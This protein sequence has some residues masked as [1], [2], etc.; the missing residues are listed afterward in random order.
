MSAEQQAERPVGTE[1]FLDDEDSGEAAR[2]VEQH[3][4]LSDMMTALSEMMSGQ[5]TMD[6]LGTIRAWQM[7]CAFMWTY[8]EPCPTADHLMGPLLAQEESVSALASAIE[9]HK[10]C[11]DEVKGAMKAYAHASK[12]LL[13]RMTA[14][15]WSV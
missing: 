3:L 4:D 11:P 2:F 7:D 13:E 14:K 9:L 1:S 12:E 5:S 6:L 8:G 10:D 15:Y